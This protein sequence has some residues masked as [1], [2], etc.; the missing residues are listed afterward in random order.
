MPHYMP[1]NRIRLHL[2]GTCKLLL[3]KGKNLNRHLIM[4]KRNRMLVISCNEENVINY[5][6]IIQ[7]EKFFPY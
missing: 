6:Q 4:C 7:R 5:I 2:E 1:N 3:K